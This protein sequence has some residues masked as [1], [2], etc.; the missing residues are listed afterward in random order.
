MQLPLGS[1]RETLAY[2]VWA[3]QKLAKIKEM[4]LLLAIAEEDPQSPGRARK[5]YKEWVRTFW[6]PFAGS[7]AKQEAR[8]RKVLD[9][10]KGKAIT[11]RRTVD[12]DDNM[13]LELEA[14]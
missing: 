10:V 1:L 14:R 3:E 2:H 9:R 4:E 6:T 8:M 5:A 12:L 7:E 11:I 13:D